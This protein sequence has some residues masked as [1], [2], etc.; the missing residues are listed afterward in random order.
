MMQRKDPDFAGRFKKNDTAEDFLTRLN[1]QV[2][3]LNDQYV[4]KSPPAHPSVFILGVPRSGTTLLTQVLAQT[5][6]IGYV[7]NLMAAFWRA[8]LVGLRLQQQVLDTSEPP[9]FAS[10]FGRTR[11]S[12]GIHEFGYFWSEALCYK[13][14]FNSAAARSGTV[15]WDNLS[16]VLAGIVNQAQQPFL[17]KNVLL[18]WHAADLQEHLDKSVFVVIRRD[19]AETAVSLLRMRDGMLGTRDKWVSAKP[20]TYPLLAERTAL[21]QV[22]GQV[23]GIQ[24]EIDEQVSRLDASRVIELEFEEF[25]RDPSAGMEAVGKTLASVGNEGLRR[26]NKLSAFEN[27]TSAVSELEPVRHALDTMR[28]LLAETS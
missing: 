21:E 18:N 17:Y 13:E 14:L 16:A 28:E 10:E 9:D 12:S 23:L 25:C 8:P 11:G 26:A 4:E 7:S 5:F 24:Q 27:H 20:A 6:E 1:D 19:L 3:E 15:D 22:A 2:K